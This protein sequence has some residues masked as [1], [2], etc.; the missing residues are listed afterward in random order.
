[1]SYMT[2]A[3]WI[4]AA[5]VAA[6][7]AAN[8]YG[9]S[10]ANRQANSVLLDALKQSKENGDDVTKKIMEAIPEYETDNR[11][12]QQEAL[13]DQTKQAISQ[14]VEN[15][16]L[17]TATKGGTQ[18]DVSSD[19]TTARARA[20]AQTLEDVRNLAQMMGAVTSAQRLRQN[21]GFRL[22][23]LQNEINLMNSF[24]NGN[25]RVA[26]L[27]AQAK[28]NGQQGWKLGGQIASALGSAISMGAGLASA[29]P[30]AAGGSSLEYSLANEA[31]GP[32]L[33]G[34]KV[35]PGAQAAFANGIVSPQYFNPGV[36]SKLGGTGVFGG[37]I[38]PKS[39]PS[40]TGGISK[41][42]SGA[43]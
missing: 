4:G 11:L 23:D 40:V 37:N 5:L 17:N 36:F 16:Q 9:T 20:N 10:K 14:P 13:S 39:L 15:V 34:A 18:G 12:K 7:T 28:A 19:Y 8:A 3:A 6:G 41:Y 2:A 33:G 35:T 42:L 30:T 1:M 25:Q 24:N 26:Q 31:M 43:R 27:R 22:A 38:L 32:M 29:A 21:E